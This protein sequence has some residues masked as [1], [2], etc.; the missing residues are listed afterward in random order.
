MI[1]ELEATCLLKPS[2][3]IQ[4]FSC[5]K[6]EAS[7]LHCQHMVDKLS[8]CMG[9]CERIHQTVVPLNYARHSLRSLTMWLLTVP[10]ALVKDFGFVTGPVL[11]FM[12]GFLYNFD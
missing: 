9:Q 11:A 3:I 8:R 2:N 10:L 12:V 6:R 1:T 7:Q 4:N 5:C